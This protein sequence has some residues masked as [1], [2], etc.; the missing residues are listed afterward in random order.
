MNRVFPE[1]TEFTSSFDE[2][3]SMKKRVKFDYMLHGTRIMVNVIK[4]LLF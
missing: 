3:I 4:C 2:D 1:Y